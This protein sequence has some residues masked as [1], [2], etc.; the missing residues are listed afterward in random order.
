M[1]TLYLRQFPGKHRFERVSRDDWE[2]RLPLRDV[3][4]WGHVGRLEGDVRVFS[5]DGDLLIC[6]KW[7]SR[8]YIR[9]FARTMRNIFGENVQLV[10][11]NGTLRTVAL[12]NAPGVGAA[13][14]IPQIIQET[15]G[16]GT[17][18]N[19]DFSGGAMAIGNGVAAEV[20]T[21]NDLVSR[22]GGIYSARQNLVTTV[23]TTATV[24]LQITTGIT[25]GQAASVN[26]TEI[27]LFLF[28]IPTG[29]T[30]SAVPFSTL[31][32]YD[33]ITS[34]PVA[35]G[36]VIAPRYTLDFPI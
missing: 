35:S 24:T 27:G 22:V 23:L 10:D 14:L 34:T 4:G 31:F 28:A 16:A 15:T 9:N 13:G 36:G 7:V 1:A 32:A 3:A 18:A 2:A 6:R 29:V 20:H 11:R 25:N 12:N 19:P 21:R 26:I 17:A 33:G 8:S 5:P 30:P